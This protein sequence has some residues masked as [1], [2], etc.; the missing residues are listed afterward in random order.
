MSRPLDGVRVLDLT[1]VLSGTSV[2]MALGDLGA[3]VIRVESRHH[4]PSATKGPRRVRA[5]GV[6]ALGNT[7]R[8][9]ADRDPG[10]EP[11]NRFAVA[12]VNAREKRSV[13]L[14][15]KSDAGRAAFMGLVARA[16]VLAE[17]NAPGFL[18][19][20]GY[21]P[22]QLFDVNPRLVLLRMPGGATDGPLAEIRG[23]GPAFE[24]FA[25][26]RDARG[27]PGL[28]PDRQPDSMYMD[29]TTGPAAVA[30]VVAALRERD[31]TG[32]G[33]LIVLSQLGVMMDHGADLY[34]ADRHADPPRENWSSEMAPHGIYPCSGDDEWLAVSCRSDDEWRALADVVGGAPLATTAALA[35][36]LAATTAL[37]AWLGTWTAARAKRDAF[38][39]LQHG[40][41]TAAPV[42]REGELLTDRHLAARE[43]FLDLDHP[44]IGV[45]RTPG[46]AW[47]S[48]RWRIAAERAAPLL[49]E[50]NDEVLGDLLGYD[51]EQLRA[52]RDS[53]EIGTGYT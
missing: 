44:L 28:P 49:G 8:G 29:A 19:R 13:T 33:A 17:N 22:R 32:S 30:A 52:L 25:G 46:P 27:Y 35:E 15:I 47:R 21:A 43:F 9:Y 23:L 14:E 6:E 40:G 41:V 3:D 31:R 39:R 12:N 48:D 4:Y 45:R 16:D 38:A 36:R 42:M 51:Q 7:R 18:E 10:D 24:A 50:H 11:W 20:R 5:E 37:D 26:L 2:T 34:G 1:V 53:G